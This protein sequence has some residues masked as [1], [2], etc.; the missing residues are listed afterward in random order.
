MDS[1][2]YDCTAKCQVKNEYIC[3]KD[4]EDYSKCNYYCPDTM[5]SDCEERHQIEDSLEETYE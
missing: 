3:C 5:N 2:K 1:K 4:C